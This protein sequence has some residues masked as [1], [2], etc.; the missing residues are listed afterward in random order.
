MEFFDDS[1]AT[2]E[3]G[4]NARAWYITFIRT[5]LY[6]TPRCKRPRPTRNIIWYYDTYY[7]AGGKQ[8]NEIIETYSTNRTFTVDP[9]Y[10]GILLILLF[11]ANN[12]PRD[13]VNT[14]QLCVQ[15]ELCLRSIITII[16]ANTSDGVII[17]YTLKSLSYNIMIRCEVGDSA[18]GTTPMS[19]SPARNRH[20]L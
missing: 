13:D 6:Y 18:S 7:I 10:N 14:V 20:A 19:I 5:I 4:S 11:W 15:C 2:G 3:V 8:A 12:G 1:E 17:L 9:S 16:V